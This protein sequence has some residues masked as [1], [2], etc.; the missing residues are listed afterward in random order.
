MRSG[1]ASVSPV[2]ETEQRYAK[3]RGLP[4][5]PSPVLLDAASQGDVVVD[6]PPDSQVHRQVVRKDA[7]AREIKLNPVVRLHYVEVREPD[8][9]DPSG[10]LRR[11]LEALE[12]EWQLHRARLRLRRSSASCRRRCARAN[13]KSRPP[14]TTPR[15]SIALWPGFHDKAYGMAVD[16]GSTTVAAHL[17]DLET[18]E[19]VAAAGTMNPQ[20]RFGEDLMSRVSYAM[21]NP[22]G[23]REMTDAIRGAL[24]ELAA[25]AR[26]RGRHRDRPTSSRS[27]LVGN[28]I[29][30][31]LV[32]GI[33]PVELGGAP[34]ALAVDQALDA[35]GLR[36][37]ASRCTRTRAST[38]C[39][40]SPAMS[41]PTRPA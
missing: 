38:C 39:P 3:R 15:R 21:M 27:T 33:D 14:C 28:P 12:R 20:I 35:A 10:D 36:R 17:C 34:F 8:M 26:A 24:G 7:D 29:M 31:H 4:A 30:H 32:L 5:G 25:R 13:G 16:V 1:A 37:S 2:S 6:V 11:L 41:A 19:L 18:G 9:H 23:A 40:A 22:G